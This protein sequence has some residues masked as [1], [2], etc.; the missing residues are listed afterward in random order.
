METWYTGLKKIALA[1]LQLRR[2]VM[3]RE[4][5]YFM[6]P[7]AGDPFIGDTMMT[8]NRSHV[9]ETGTVQLGLFPALFQ[10]LDEGTTIKAPK[11]EMIFP[12]VVT[13]Q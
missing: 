11:P 7:R 10:T 1:A 2:Q 4:Q 3:L 13:L 6:W 9:D 8:E 12:A 5:L